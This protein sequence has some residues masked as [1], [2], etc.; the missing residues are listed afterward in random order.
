[1]NTRTVI[2]RSIAA[3]AA[4]GATLLLVAGTASAA[5]P[6]GPD[7]Q[8]ACTSNY[9]AGAQS[10]DLTIQNN[11]GQTITL[12]GAHTTD[13]GDGHWGARPQATL[14]PGACEE[15]TG[16]SDDPLSDYYITATYQLPDGTYLPFSAASGSDS[17]NTQVFTS[18]G[19]SGSAPGSFSGKWDFNWAMTD[20]H[21]AGSE[22]IHTTI[23]AE[24]GT[25]S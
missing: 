9:H 25:T 15:L 24:P 19:F 5:E 23:A 7:E 4:T 11:T 16:Y 17:Y 8:A 10:V 1:M 12:V 13:G 14:A 18:G 2:T 22:H 21:W 3:L 20:T 6:S